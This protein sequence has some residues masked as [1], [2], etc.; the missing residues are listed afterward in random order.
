MASFVKVLFPSAADTDVNYVFHQKID[1]CSKSVV[2][3]N[4]RMARYDKYNK[5]KY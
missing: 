4:D 5:D 3:R 2:Q 1:W